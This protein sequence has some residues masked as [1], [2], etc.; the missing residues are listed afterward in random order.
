M[1]GAMKLDLRQAAFQVSRVLLVY[2]IRNSGRVQAEDVPAGDPV[3]APQL[4]P[5]VPATSSGLD[6]P[7]MPVYARLDRPTMNRAL[8]QGHLP[9]GT[10]VSPVNTFIPEHAEKNANPDL[11]T[12]EETVTELKRRLGKELYR[13]ELDLQN[14]GRIAGKVCDCLSKAKHSAGIE[15]T[16]EELM[17][18]EANPIY[19]EVIEWI[20][21][22]AREFEPA[23]IAKRPPAY[24]Q[25]LTPEIRNFRK[26]VMGT[27]NAMALTRNGG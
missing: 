14:G 12:T 16:A 25:E 21:S 9:K 15:A 17:S 1:I 7:T 23:E 27:D 24:Y 13:V 18:Y 8:D 5:V 6:L 22:H 4:H 3:P 11:P 10:W 20:N 26:K 2:M 19:G